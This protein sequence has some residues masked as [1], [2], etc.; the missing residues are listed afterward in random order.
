MTF[1]M[2]FQ[3]HGGLAIDP[4]G[5]QAI[6]GSRAGRTGAELKVMAAIEAKLP[7]LG[8]WELANV[9]FYGRKLGLTVDLWLINR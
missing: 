1:S 3:H 9:F 6:F 4:N 2:Y 7:P 5:C 8:G